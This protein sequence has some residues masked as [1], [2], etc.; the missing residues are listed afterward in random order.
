MTKFELWVF[1]TQENKQ[2]TDFLSK[3]FFVSTLLC[4][5]GDLSTTI[6]KVALL[7][8]SF[9][10]TQSKL[11]SLSNNKCITDTSSL[12]ILLFFVIC[13]CLPPGGKNKWQK[14]GV[15][16][17]SLYRTCYCLKISTCSKWHKNLKKEEQLLRLWWKDRQTQKCW[18]KKQFT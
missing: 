6:L 2:K 18:N 14:I 4:L 17:E 10:V 5:T 11:K 8:S 16:K 15:C 7:F 13:F 9:C 3:L 1:V 12:C